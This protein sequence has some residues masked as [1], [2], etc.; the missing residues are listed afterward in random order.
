VV[1]SGSDYEN[2][3]HSTFM[4]DLWDDAPAL[5]CYTHRMMRG[6]SW[7]MIAGLVSSLACDSKEEVKVDK[8][9][10]SSKT[11]AVPSDFVLNP[12]LPEDNNKKVAL[13][14][15]SDGGVLE[16]GLLEGAGAAAADSTNAGA[17]D[18]SNLETTLV[19][20]GQEPRTERRYAFTLG[21]A[22]T[23][24]VTIRASANQGGQTQEQPP[25]KLT[26]AITAQKKTA[27]GFAVEA[28]LMK[29][30]LVPANDAEK[31][32][33]AQANQAFASLAGLAAQY[34][35]ST[36]GQ[37]SEPQ[38]PG[39]DPKKARAAQEIL[40]MMVQALEA[41]YPPLPKA[42]IGVGAKWESK[43]KPASEQGMVVESVSAFTLKS[44]TGDAG[45]IAGTIKRTA[46]KQPVND[47]RLPPG[48][49]MSLDGTSTMD[50]T[51]RLDKPATKLVGDIVQNVT[52]AAGPKTQNQT[53]KMKL[54]VDS[55]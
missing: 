26:L 13:Q 47:P 45:N 42:A 8:S 33:A 50:W 6:F 30:E 27:K 2:Q 19:E 10:T 21:K 16:A 55:P 9:K 52:L 17:A 23:R 32:M 29:V 34:E 53:V 24:A 14:V 46:S 25:I 35:V 49:S 18:P 11:E 22:D 38:F 31:A 12:F 20:P 5:L 1:F 51:L 41:L 40:P 7:M 44:W 37:S 36:L 39:I 48:A 15:K 3:A 28:K 43:A 54:T 4:H